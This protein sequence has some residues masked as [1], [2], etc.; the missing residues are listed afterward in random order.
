MFIVSILYAGLV[1]GRVFKVELRPNSKSSLSMEYN[2]LLKSRNRY[3]VN[4]VKLILIGQSRPG[5]HL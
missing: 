3:K 1:C 4:A 5:S 2:T